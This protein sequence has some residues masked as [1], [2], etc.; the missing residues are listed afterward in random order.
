MT[1]LLATLAHHIHSSVGH[2]T[3]LFDLTSFDLSV[4]MFCQLSYNLAL[5]TTAF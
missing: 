3:Y 1:N 5:V 4:H 2:K